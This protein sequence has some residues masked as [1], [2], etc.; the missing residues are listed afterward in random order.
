MGD[1]RP[2][3]YKDQHRRKELLRRG[4]AHGQKATPLP[5]PVQVAP[6]QAAAGTQW[7]ACSEGL[8]PERLT[9]PASWA[10]VP[11]AR[12]EAGGGRALQAE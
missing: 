8:D 9:S 1:A 2:A 11:E 6:V 10:A 3:A 7:V 4:Q 12:P 5:W